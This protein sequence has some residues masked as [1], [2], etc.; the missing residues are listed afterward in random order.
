[1]IVFQG[2]PSVEGNGMSSLYKLQVKT[3]QVTQLGD[4]VIVFHCHSAFNHKRQESMLV[5]NMCL[6]H[7]VKY[8]VLT[9]KTMSFQSGGAILGPPGAPG[10]P[11]SIIIVMPEANPLQCAVEKHQHTGTLVL[12]EPQNLGELNNK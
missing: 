2:V 10:A 11:V 8:I 12:Y 7:I 6:T 5:V 9:F 4:N 1:M 3:F